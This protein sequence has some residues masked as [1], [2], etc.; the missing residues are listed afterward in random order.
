MPRTQEFDANEALDRAVALFWKKG[1]FDSSMDDLV[2]ATGVS[3]YGIYGTFG[4]KREFFKAS[5][6]SYAD[7]IVS[8]MQRPLRKRD[9]SL[10]EIQEYFAKLLQLA[11]SDRGRLGCLICNTATEVAPHDEDVGRA[12]RAVFD[13]YSRVFKRALRNAQARGEIGKDRDI[14]A[15]AWYLTG[16]MQGMAVMARAGYGK[17]RI[18][19]FVKVAMRTLR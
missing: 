11:G 3:R 14:S 12:V 4:N 2:K 1:F 17:E 19:E 13:E 18:R 7:R 5:L 8:H 10:A 16:V 9:A 15:L 6:R